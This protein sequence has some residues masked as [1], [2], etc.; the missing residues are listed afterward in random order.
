MHFQLKPITG[1]LV[2]AGAMAFALVAAPGFA[3]QNPCGAKPA[4]SKAANPCA[5]ESLCRQEPMR[6]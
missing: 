3:A 2:A 6:G 4:A 1:A 5:K